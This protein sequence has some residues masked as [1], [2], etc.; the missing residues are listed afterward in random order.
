MFI[1]VTTVHTVC[2]NKVEDPTNDQIYSLVL[3]LISDDLAT[4]MGRTLVDFGHPEPI[5]A[6]EELQ[7]EGNRL[8]R[9][10]LEN[11]IPHVKEQ[12]E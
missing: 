4:T 7:V 12:L 6:L 1:L 2:N 11:D 10:Q 5:I 8:I 9:D 3:N